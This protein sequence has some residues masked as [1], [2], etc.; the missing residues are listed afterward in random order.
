M[1]FEQK[2][3]KAVKIRERNLLRAAKIAA[4]KPDTGVV[5]QKKGAYFVIKD[6]ATITQKYLVHLAYSSLSNPI[7]DLRGKFTEADIINFVGRSKTEP[8]TRQLLHIILTDIGSLQFKLATGT[9]TS[10]P[11]VSVTAPIHDYTIKG[12]EDVYG[13]YNFDDNNE[14]EVI[15]ITSSDTVDDIDVD[16][17]TAVINKLVEVFGVK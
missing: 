16:D 13:D 4:E 12:D 1:K 10:Q 2:I 9:D 14:E 8:H 11:P 7:V 3:L 17:A 5:I 6:C 15:E